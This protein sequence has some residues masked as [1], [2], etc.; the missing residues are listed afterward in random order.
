[1]DDNNSQNTSCNQ[2]MESQIETKK[3]LH[4]PKLSMS[5]LTDRVYGPTLT[6]HKSIANLRS[7][8]S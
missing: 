7:S 8:S 1:M 3:R 2:K 6:A 5:K 4:L